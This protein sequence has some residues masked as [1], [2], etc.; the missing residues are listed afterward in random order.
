MNSIRRQVTWL[1]IALIVLVTF[2]AAITGYRASME[3]A[4][5][6]FDGE[7]RAIASTLISLPVDHISNT[8]EIE[9]PPDV[10]WQLWQQDRL[11]MRSDNAPDKRITSIKKRV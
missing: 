7:L 3:D 1:L 5:R 6:L 2:S 8:M 11:L 4:T 10:A 9:S